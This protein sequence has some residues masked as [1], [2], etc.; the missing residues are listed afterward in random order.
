MP[1][2]NLSI[3]L[4]VIELRVIKREELVAERS[5]KEDDSPILP[6]LIKDLEAWSWYATFKI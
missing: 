2:E 3:A 4:A 1:A 6:F 5:R